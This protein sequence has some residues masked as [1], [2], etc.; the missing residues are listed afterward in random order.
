MDF[1]MGDEKDGKS[2]LFDFFAKEGRKLKSY[3]RRRLRTYS[4][5]DAEDIVEEVMLGV[6][7]K[8]DLTSYAENLAAYVY[9]SLRNRI[10]DHKRRISRTASIRGFINDDV[11]TPLLDLIA[12]DGKSVSSEVERKEL[13]RRLGEAIGK[14][15]P[16]QRAVFIATEMEG[17]SFRELSEQWNEPIGTLLSRKSRAVRTLREMLKDLKEDQ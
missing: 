4:E 2:G 6:I 15:E 14:L 11:D 9:R 1:G 10:I 13:I 12:D 8:A 17:I 3:V 5:M 7:Q 16:K